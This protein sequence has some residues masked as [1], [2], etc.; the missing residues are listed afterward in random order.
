MSTYV[1]GSPYYIVILYNAIIGVV[2]IKSIAPILHFK[3]TD[4]YVVRIIYEN[5]GFVTPCI[6]YCGRSILT[7][8]C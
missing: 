4:I 7:N 3:S 6:D 8:N 5:H 2:E 1:T